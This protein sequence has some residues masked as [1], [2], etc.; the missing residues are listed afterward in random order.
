MPYPMNK[1]QDK[2]FLITYNESRGKQVV[3]AIKAIVVLVVGLMLA[4]VCLADAQQP[5]KFHLRA[6]D[7]NVSERIGVLVPNTAAL[8]ANNADALRQG[9]RELGYVEGQNLGIEYRYAEGNLNWLPVLA[10]ELVRLKVNVI[11]AS[12]SAAVSAARDATKEIPIIF[13]TTGDPVARGLVASLARP[14]GNITGVTLANSE[15]Y[16]KRLELLKEI[17]PRLSLA[18]I[19]FNPTDPGADMGMKE[20][21]ESGK[22]LG[23]RVESLE[24]RNANDIDRAFESATRLKV[25]AL[26]FIHHPPITTYQKQ[27][28]ELA[29]KSRLPAIYASTE[30]CESGGLISYGRSF[31]DTHRRL[32][33]YVDKVLK[34]AKPSDLPVEQWKKLELVINL[35][36]AKQI[37]LTVPPEVLA[38]ADKVIK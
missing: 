20:A 15:L 8:F 31:P 21:G 17:I 18:A 12:S 5:G 35:K 13:S 26:T 36:A 22:A 4:S 28:V 9:L 32:A 3:M 27:V 11:V 24:V 34:G 10:T 2:T 25:G 7:G 30:W 37:G 6:M 16:G 38:R 1:G 19:L 29:V 33:V 14:G 23:I